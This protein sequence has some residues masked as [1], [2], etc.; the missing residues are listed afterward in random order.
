MPSGEKATEPTQSVCPFSVS[1]SLPVVASHTFT[2]LS[3]LPVTTRL[4]S[5]E[6][7]MASIVLWVAVSNL[8]NRVNVS[9]RQPA[10][11]WG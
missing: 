7:Q 5:G 8:F 10:G 3:L 6:K 4:P 9:I 1:V 2:V 11:V